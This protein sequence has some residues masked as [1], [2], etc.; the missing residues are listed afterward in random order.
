LDQSQLDRQKSWGPACPRR[1]GA[2]AEGEALWCRWCCHGI[3]HHQL[4]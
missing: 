1:R 3:L 2:S 4:W